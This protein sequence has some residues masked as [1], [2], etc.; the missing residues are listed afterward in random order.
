MRQKWEKKINLKSAK[1]RVMQ[2][3]I[4]NDFGHDFTENYIS[5][6]FQPVLTDFC[7]FDSLHKLLT[8]YVLTI[9]SLFNIFPSFFFIFNL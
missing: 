2:S 1:K 7:L 9:L 4:K 8:Y 5:L 3:R 6:E